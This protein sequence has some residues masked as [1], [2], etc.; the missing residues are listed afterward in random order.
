MG[1]RPE[2]SSS[3][4]GLIA[5]WR[6][7]AKQ[8][9]TYGASQALKSDREYF[10]TVN[11]AIAISQCAE[12][13]DAALRAAPL[14]G[15]VIEKYWN[16]ELQYWTGRFIDARGWSSKHD[17]ARRFAR[18]EDASIVL[19]W[20]LNGEGRAVEHL[21]QAALRAEGGPPP[22]AK[23][24]EPWHQQMHHLWTTAVGQEG[25]VKTKWITFEATLEKLLSDREK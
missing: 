3:P 6:A 21:W 13:L 2:A 5:E 17:E 7:R 8:D 11:A 22:H 16:G 18:C 19:A 25:Y 20:L 24:E 12:E 23:E 14:S 1:D 9:A 10:G 15:W 4:V